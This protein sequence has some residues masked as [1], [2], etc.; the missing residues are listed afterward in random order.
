MENAARLISTL[1]FPIFCALVLGYV[2]YKLLQQQR[3]D[4]LRR[5]DRLFLQLDSFSKSLDNFNAT[6]IK[7]DT[8]LEAVENKLEK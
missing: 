3:E 5:E 4:N 1:G 6:L 8:R 2:G 7:I